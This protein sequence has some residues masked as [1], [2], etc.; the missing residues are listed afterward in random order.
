M[1]QLNIRLLAK[2]YPIIPTAANKPMVLTVH[3]RPGVG[4]TT[5]PL[6]FDLHPGSWSTSLSNDLVE[7]RGLCV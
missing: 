1:E 3:H 5:C 7:R 6:G 2:P 4:R